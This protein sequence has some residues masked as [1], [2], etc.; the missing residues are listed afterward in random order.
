MMLHIFSDAL[1]PASPTHVVGAHAT[2]TIAFD[3]DVRPHRYRTC[4]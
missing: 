1:P 3:A 4:G 2:S